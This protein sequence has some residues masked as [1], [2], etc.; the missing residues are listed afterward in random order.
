[1][2]NAF[3]SQK[4]HWSPLFQSSTFRVKDSGKIRGPKL[5]QQML[6][7]PHHCQGSARFQIVD[8]EANVS[9][10]N[11]LLNMLPNMLPKWT[12]GTR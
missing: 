5:S 2:K 1:L 12:L 8:E 3:I 9:L 11:T 10:I 7:L 4:R 6:G